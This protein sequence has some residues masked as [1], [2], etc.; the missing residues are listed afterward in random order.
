MK[1]VTSICDFCGKE[2]AVDPNNRYDDDAPEDW[3]EDW[4]ITVCPDCAAKHTIAELKAKMAAR[5]AELD[6][7]REVAIA[8]EEEKERAAEEKRRAEKELP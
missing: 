2:S 1:R 8:A 7:E 6:A 4:P 3:H 5:N